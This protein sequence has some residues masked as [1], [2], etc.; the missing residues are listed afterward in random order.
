MTNHYLSFNSV[1]SIPDLKVSAAFT[2]SSAEVFKEQG[3]INPV[4]IDEDC[5]I[6]Q[7]QPE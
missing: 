3:D 2:V 7:Y 6:R 5:C 4:T 1:E